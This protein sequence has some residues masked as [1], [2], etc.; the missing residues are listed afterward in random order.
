MSQRA[1]ISQ[2]DL[3]GE[4]AHRQMIENVRLPRRPFVP[5]VNDALRMVHSITSSATMIDARSGKHGR[6]ARRRKWITRRLRSRPGELK[7]DVMSKM[8]QP[9]HNTRR[10]AHGFLRTRRPRNDENQAA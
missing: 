7:I 1:D 10:R 2:R 4:I 9:A 5:S 6:S 8:L 3:P